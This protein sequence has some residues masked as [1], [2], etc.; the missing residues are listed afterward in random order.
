MVTLTVS[1]VPSWEK[2]V[3]LSDD[4]GHHQRVN[5]TI[6]IVD[7]IGPNA[8]N[9]YTECAEVV[10]RVR[11]CR[12]GL[13]DIVSIIYIRGIENAGHDVGRCIF[14]YCSPRDAGNYG[15]IVDRGNGDGHPCGI[16]PQITV[17]P[18]YVEEARRTVVASRGWRERH[19][20][21]FQ[22]PPDRFDWLR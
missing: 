17:V 9:R 2:T 21:P 10:S 18:Y 15:G 13:E 20:V 8:I 1:A 6:V 12:N 19:R 22:N 3:K 4:A 16:A 7:G 5:R 14:C 11:T